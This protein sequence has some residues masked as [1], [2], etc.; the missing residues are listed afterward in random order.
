MMSGVVKTL[1]TTMA[2]AA[3]AA[4]R[5]A[6]PGWRDPRLWVGVV[7]VAAC[8]VAGARILGS[9]DN[10]VAVW[11]IAGDHAAGTPLDDDDLV[12]KQV[13]FAD[14]QD[15]DGYFGIDAD[16]PPH[17]VFAHAVSDGELLPRQ[18][19]GSTDAP[20]LMEVPLSVDP[21]QVP[22]SVGEGSIVDVYVA[23]SPRGSLAQELDRPVIKAARVAAYLSATDSL[24]G[25]GQA[26]LTVAVAERGAR[27]YFAVLAAVDS[28]VVTIV[29]EP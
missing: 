6:R 3:P 29:K 13:R 5:V 7:I 20:G 24:G 9:A 28:P 25:S 12:P 15:L 17:P 26:Q 10:T 8:V 1:G 14:S 4:T 21:G 22:P 16:L 19:V 11:A 27:T 18:A 23:G 2:T